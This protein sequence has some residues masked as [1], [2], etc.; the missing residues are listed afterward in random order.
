MPSTAMLRQ[1]THIPRG[2]TLDGLHFLNP[3][4]LSLPKGGSP[5]SYGF[6]EDG[7]FRVLDM[8]DREVLRHVPAANEA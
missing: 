3:R 2:E 5:R 7:L 4:S 1:H 6:Y 8:Q